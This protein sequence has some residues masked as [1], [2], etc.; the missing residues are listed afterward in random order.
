MRNLVLAR[1]LTPG[2]HRLTV[3]N[4][5][6]PS[7]PGG[8][9]AVAILGF[10]AGMDVDP[11]AVAAGLALCAGRA[12]RASMAG[13]GRR[14]GWQAHDDQAG[15]AAVEQLYFASR[16][17]DAVRHGLRALHDQPP[18]SPMVE[19]ER[20]LWRPQPETLDYLARLSD[21]Q[22]T[23]PTRRCTGPISSDTIRSSPRP[24]RSSCKDCAAWPMRS[25]PA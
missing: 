21:T 15:L 3:T 7:Q 19:R 16:E 17:V 2:P 25:T 4:L 14:T 1:G 23:G 8:S 13:A 10:A 24:A 18:P 20:K 9:T 6:R 11:D 12:R 22:V 5:G